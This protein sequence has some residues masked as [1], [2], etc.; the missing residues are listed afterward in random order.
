MSAMINA[1]Q[2]KGRDEASPPVW[3][4]KPDVNLQVCTA[5][6]LSVLKKSDVLN[7]PEDFRLYLFPY[8]PWRKFFLLPGTINIKTHTSNEGGNQN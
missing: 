5:L 7:M 6:Y 4:E 1:K 3:Q 2:N 8:C